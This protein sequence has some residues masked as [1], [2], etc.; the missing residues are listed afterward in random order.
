MKLLTLLFLSFA[1][2][3]TYGG[4]A[5]CNKVESKGEGHWPI[6]EEHFTKSVAYDSLEKLEY[7]IGEE[8][9]SADYVSTE[10][11]LI[12]LK[13]YV[14]KKYAN[15]NDEVSLKEYC[16]FIENEAYIRH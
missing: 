4:V 1:S 16:D 8:S 14:L 15:P 6:R 2:I 3:S 9:P 11:A 13:G 10:N 7:I 12:Y 5:L